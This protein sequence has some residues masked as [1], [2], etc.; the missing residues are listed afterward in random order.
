MARIVGISTSTEDRR[1]PSR[2][3][4]VRR[5][6]QGSRSGRS[7]TAV[8]SR[9]HSGE[10]RSTRLLC[11]TVLYLR[12]GW[13]NCGLR[14]DKSEASRVCRHEKPSVRTTNA[15]MTNNGTTARARARSAGIVPAANHE[16]GATQEIYPSVNGIS[17]SR[18]EP[19]GHPDPTFASI[20]WTRFP[21]KG[22]AI[23]SAMRV[24]THRVPRANPPTTSVN[25]CAPR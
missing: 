18:P 13:Q 5:I 25:Q 8:P 12:R 20:P 10:A 3:P 9:P 16:L 24:P 15:V 7:T 1:H 17:S 19:D 22:T 2:L 23:R 6:R 4:N 11:T 21:S 14:E